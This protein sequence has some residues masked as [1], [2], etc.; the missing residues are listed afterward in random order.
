MSTQ[1]PPF[2]ARRDIVEIADDLVALILLE[3]LIGD[4]GI[5]G[6][7]A[8]IDAVEHARLA[9]E[10]VAQALEMLVPVRIFDDHPDVRVHGAGRAEDELL[11]DLAHLVEPILGP[12]TGA[13]GGDVGVALRGVEEEIVE[14]HLVE[15]MG[16]QADGALA[17]GAVGGAFIIERAELA[18]LAAGGEG[19]PARSLDAVRLEP[20]LDPLE[21]VVGGEDMV[22]IGLDIDL[23]EAQL[24]RDARE[25]AVE[26]GAVGE[27]ARVGDGEIDGGAEVAIGARRA[28]AP[29]GPGPVAAKRR[30]RARRRQGG[31]ASPMPS[32]RAASHP[33]RFMLALT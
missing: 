23:V 27:P 4:F 25:L 10:I 2:A 14:D 3:Q 29:P 18:A 11:A 13:A 16:D 22:A 33:P 21:L 24:R 15:M 19:D 20:G 8:G 31:T 6:L 7:G 17:F 26:S 32:E 5:A 28:R 9:V 1:P 30:A 12:A